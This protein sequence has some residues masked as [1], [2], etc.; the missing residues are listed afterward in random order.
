MYQTVSAS[1]S[2]SADVPLLIIKSEVT[3]ISFTI[4][5]TGNYQYYILYVVCDRWPIAE[6]KPNR[7]LGSLRCLGVWR[8]SSIW[9][10]PQ[11]LHSLFFSCAAGAFTAFGHMRLL[12][13]FDMHVELTTCLVL[14][15]RSIQASHYIHVLKATPDRWICNSVFISCTGSPPAVH[16]FLPGDTLSRIDAE[17]D[18]GLA[19]QKPMINYDSSCRRQVKICRGPDCSCADLKNAFSSQWSFT[20]PSD[21]IGALW[22]IHGWNNWWYRSQ[23][24][25]VSVDMWIL[26]CS[27]CPLMM[28]R[29]HTVLYDVPN[30]SAVV[31]FLQI[32]CTEGWGLWCSLWCRLG[33]N[34]SPPL[35]PPFSQLC[36]CTPPGVIGR[37]LVC[38]PWAKKQL[39]NLLTYQRLQS[40]VSLPSLTIDVISYYLWSHVLYIT[41]L[42]NW[43]Q[44]LIVSSKVY[45]LTPESAP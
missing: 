39:G 20:F 25:P 31:S 43:I 5:M 27:K 33:E 9:P 17:C 40:W 14:I 21:L 7:L 45:A 26:V 22:P 8:H 16:I 15:N 41:F 12:Y 42:A 4:S 13:W 35:S 3:L 2:F 6:S 24:S 36:H 23:S 11:L 34:I 1:S 44:L 30:R 28:I 32:P 19:P 10:E 18:M 38:F 37:D 29:P